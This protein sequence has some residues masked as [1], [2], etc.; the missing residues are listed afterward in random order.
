M[1][2]NPNFWHLIRGP[3]CVVSLSLSASA[4]LAKNQQINVAYQDHHNVRKWREKQKNH[5]HLSGA[6]AGKIVCPNLPNL[7]KLLMVDPNKISNP[8]FPTN[9]NKQHHYFGKLSN[10]HSKS[11]PS[12]PANSELEWPEVGWRKNTWCQQDMDSSWTSCM[13]QREMRWI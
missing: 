13:T 6:T 9:P 1:S 2:K 8:W 11:V 12:Y 3:K 7:S 10:L 4:K 5:K